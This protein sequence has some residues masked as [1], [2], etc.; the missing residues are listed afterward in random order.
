M[1]NRFVLIEYSVR[2]TKIEISV[3]ICSAPMVD[4]DFEGFNPD[5]P[6]ISVF[7]SNQG[8]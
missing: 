5:F 7:V 2:V 6:G 3:E 8:N 1:V 4:F